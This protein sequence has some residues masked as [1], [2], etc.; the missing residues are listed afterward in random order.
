[1]KTKVFTIL[2]L[3][4]ESYGPPFTSMTTATGLRQFQELVN[5]HNHF[6]SKYPDDYELY[7]IGEWED[8]NASFFPHEVKKQLCRG[9]DVQDRAA[10]D[11]LKRVE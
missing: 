1:M 2:D 9:S 4:A 10:G 3:K 11:F 7:E 6:F 8:E 5:D